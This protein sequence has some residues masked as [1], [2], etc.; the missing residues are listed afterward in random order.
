MNNVLELL[1]QQWI[2]SL[3]TKDRS[4]AAVSGNFEELFESLKNSGATF[5][6]AHEILP[7]AVKAHQP[8]ASLTRAQYKNLKKKVFDF[9][10]T[11]KE[12][13]EEWNRSIDDKGTAAFF[14]FFPLP[15]MD[16]DGEPKVYGNMSAKEYKAQRRYAE[17]F[18]VL[19]TTE[20]EKRMNER[21]YNLD[22]EDMLKHVLGEDSNG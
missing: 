15:K 17:Q 9:D 2:A 3:K 16:E 18:P 22:I 4:A 10:K 20:L 12:F 8:V 14:E 13:T 5:E 6:E 1:L 19:D 7:K 21:E 11:E